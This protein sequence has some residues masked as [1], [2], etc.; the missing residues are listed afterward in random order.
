MAERNA[1]Q[2]RDPTSLTKMMTSYIIGQTIKAGKISMNDIVTIDENA[3]ATGNPVL[4]A[5]R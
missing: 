4:K 5:L 3:W 2:R 1:D